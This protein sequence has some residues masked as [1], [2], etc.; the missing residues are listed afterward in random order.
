[1][2]RMTKNDAY[3]FINQFRIHVNVLR[4]N[5]HPLND[6]NL[7]RVVFT[8]LLTD[9]HWETIHAIQD[10]NPT[11]TTNQLLEHVESTASRAMEHQTGVKVAIAVL[12]IKTNPMGMKKK[13]S[14]GS[15]SIKCFHCQR[16]CHDY[17]E[18]QKQFKEW[19]AKKKE[20]KVDGEI[21]T[22]NGMAA[23]EKEDGE[24]VLLDSAASRHIMNTKGW[25]ATYSVCSTPVQFGN[26]GVLMSEG[27]GDVAWEVETGEGVR[28]VM[29]KDVLHVPGVSINLVS[30]PR[31]AMDGA[32]AHF[33]S[34]GAMM[35]VQ[36]STLAAQL[37]NRLYFLDGCPSI[38]QVYYANITYADITTWHKHLGHI[39]INCLKLLMNGEMV[40]RLVVKG[41]NP[42]D[43]AACHLSKQA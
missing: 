21:A 13:F 40:D 8:A 25:F 1:M 27:R 24:K 10:S 4:A 38:I 11:I 28:V 30:I 14:S 33:M 12:M 32:E 35:Q 36:G 41:M 31:L 5:G 19:L 16:D 15:S 17:L 2:L 29:F 9:A 37:K 7:K 22:E 42:A 20:G 3:V 23:W 39:G 43:C 6:N 18:E 34:Q 26:K